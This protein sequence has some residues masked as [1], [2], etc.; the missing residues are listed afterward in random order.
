MVLDLVQK[1]VTANF[2]DNNDMYDTF[3]IV[4][5]LVRGIVYIED[6]N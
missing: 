1:F 6:K 5:K 3:D 2:K 4:E